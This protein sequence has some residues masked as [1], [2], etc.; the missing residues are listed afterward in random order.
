MLTRTGLGVTVAAVLL[1]G[2]GLTFGYRELAVVGVAV[3]M[4]VVVALWAAR[5]PVRVEVRRRLTAPRVARTD[6]IRIVY[7][8]ANRT[9]FRS[10]RFALVDRCDGRVATTAVEPLP[11]GSS[12][13]VT[14]TIA[15]RRRGIF[16][17]GPCR[18]ER[19]DALEC[20]VGRSSVADRLQ[21]LVHPRIHPIVG[22]AGRLHQSERESTVRR[23]SSDPMSG[24]VSLRQ[25][26]SGDDPRLIHWPTTARVGSL[27][28][29]EHVDQRRPQFTVIVDTSDNSATPDDFE[30]VVDAAAS[31]AAHAVE[32]GLDVVVRTTS[33]D[34]PG[35][36]DPLRDAVGV[37]ELLTPVGQT[38]GVDLLSL[39]SLFT[40][41]F[42]Q[43]AI[44]LLT[45][46]T[47]PSSSLAD[48]A[49]SLTVRIG[50][51]AVAGAGAAMAVRD[52]REFAL[53]WQG[54]R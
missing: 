35:R 46:P 38:S 13:R 1:V 24:F 20:A 47:G 25:Y 29:R 7:D 45:G 33:R 43:S 27:M 18:A 26:V 21:V 50:D 3:L 32:H 51:G 37:L 9:R 12:A 39:A 52:A 44:L 36:P 49:G 17:V 34:H 41:G 14:A 40:A 2:A 22:P 4:L 54:A 16:D 30:E 11:T 28:V 6:P 42:D 48:S 5:R 8:V 31:A 23:A 53:R 15:T 10:A 19:T